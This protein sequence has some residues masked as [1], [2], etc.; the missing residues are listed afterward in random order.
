MGPS[1]GPSPPP[2]P[3]HPD[4]SVGLVCGKLKRVSEPPHVLIVGPK[5]GSFEPGQAAQRR[6]Q[7]HGVGVHGHVVERGVGH[8]EAAPARGR[9]LAPRLQVHVVQEARGG[10]DGVAVRVRSAVRDGVLGGRDEGEVRG[11]VRGRPAAAAG[12]EQPARLCS[13]H[14]CDEKLGLAKVLG[15]AAPAGIRRHC[16]GPRGGGERALDEAETGRRRLS[17]H[18][19]SPGRRIGRLR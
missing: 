7:H 14:E 10:V 9:K 5:H 4:S 6:I 15:D 16:G 3:A 19:G 1:Q 2:T 12:P 11:E 8:H 18:P 13:A 17:T